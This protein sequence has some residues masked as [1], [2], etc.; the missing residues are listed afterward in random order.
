MWERMERAAGLLLP[1]AV[2]PGSGIVGKRD[3]NAAG[4]KSGVRVMEEVQLK[5]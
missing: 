1:L 4:S 2:N 3:S 5:E